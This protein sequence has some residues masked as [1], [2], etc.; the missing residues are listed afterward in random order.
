MAGNTVSARSEVQLLDLPTLGA[1]NHNGGAVHVGPDGKL[2]LGVGENAVASNSQSLNSPLG[3]ILRINADGTIPSNNPFFSQTTG[4]NRSHLGDGLRNPF[5]FAFDPLTAT[6]TSTTWAR[7]TFEEINLGEAGAN[8]GWP[9]PRRQR[10]GAHLRR[11]PL[12]IRPRQRGDDGMRDRR[13]RL[14]PPDH[15]PLRLL[16]SPATTSSPTSATAG[17]AATTRSPTPR[18]AS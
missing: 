17:S 12:P 1:G 14:L 5:T 15:Q 4:I 13:R 3:K 6:C 7:S 2:Y 10:R 11:S 18:P 16:R 9:D 8:Y